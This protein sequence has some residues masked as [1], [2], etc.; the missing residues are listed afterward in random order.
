MPL[1]L[2]ILDAPDA[3]SYLS[4]VRAYLEE[5]VPSFRVV[6]QQLTYILDGERSVLLSHWSLM[7]E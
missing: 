4:D 6:L 7:M 2:R 3:V 1:N 5:D